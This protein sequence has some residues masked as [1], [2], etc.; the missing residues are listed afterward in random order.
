M[1]PEELSGIGKVWDRFG[2]SVTISMRG[3]EAA[4]LQ[5]KTRA[6]RQGGGVD[7]D[8]YLIKRLSR[9]YMDSDIPLNGVEFSLPQRFGGVWRGESH[10]TWSCF[11]WA[12]WLIGGHGCMMTAYPFSLRVHLVGWTMQQLKIWCTICFMVV[13]IFYAG[14]S[15]SV[16]LLL[17]EAPLG[18]GNDWSWVRWVSSATCQSSSMEPWDTM[19]MGVM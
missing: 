19:S 9:L 12:Y 4:I 7:Q 16:N 17:T 15:S 13:P 2:K 3:L 11:Q 10:Q 1:I 8:G 5:S 6:G 14:I 18:P